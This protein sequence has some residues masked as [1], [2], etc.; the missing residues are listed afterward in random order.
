MG[1]KKKENR[2]S[3]RLWKRVQKIRVTWAFVM[4]IEVELSLEGKLVEVQEPLVDHNNL[5]SVN[6]RVL[7]MIL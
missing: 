7:E 5:C 1:S 4:L 6:K 3:R 2:D